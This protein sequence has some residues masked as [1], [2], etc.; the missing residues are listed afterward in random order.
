MSNFTFAL[1]GYDLVHVMCLRIS[2]RLY[3]LRFISFHKISNFFIYSIFL[4][5]SSLLYVTPCYILMILVVLC[6]LYSTYFWQP[7]IMLHRIHWLWQWQPSKF[8]LHI[9]LVVL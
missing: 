4:S 1:L 6:E 8:E 3:A 7:K 5:F 9:D 2:A